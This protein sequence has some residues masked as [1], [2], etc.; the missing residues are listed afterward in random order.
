VSLR[1]AF[2]GVRGSFPC[3]DARFSRYGGHTSSVHV[4]VNGLDILLD[5]GTGIRDLGARLLA[6]E[7]RSF[8]LLLSHTHWDHVCGLPFFTPAYDPAVALDIRAGHLAARGGLAAALET[9]VGDPFFPLPF[10][11]L[12]ASIAVRDFE[13]GDTFLLGD[14]VRVRTAPLR[15]PGGATGYRIEHDGASVCYVTDTEHTPGSL[16]LE[17]LGLING[18][19]LVIYDSTYTDA[20]LPQHVGWGHSTWEE[21]VRLCKGA[22]AKRL[23]IFH[24]DPDHDDPFMDGVAAAARAAWPGAF[25]AREGMTVEVDHTEASVRPGPGS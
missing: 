16:D 4:E 21:G 1:V 6:R 7:R 24:H 17:I 14:G 20:Q 15:H 2:A 23:A 10:S 12:R 11:A 5:A 22:G 19:D 3:P 18:A 25:V 8:V 13:P 9:A